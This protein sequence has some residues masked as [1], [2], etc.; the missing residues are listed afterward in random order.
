VGGSTTLTKTGA[1]TIAYQMTAA[2]GSYALSG[3]GTTFNHTTSTPASAPQAMWLSTVTSNSVE[4]GWW[5][6]IDGSVPDSYN[7]YR[8]DLGDGSPIATGIVPRAYDTTV[9]SV[10]FLFNNATGLSSSTSYTFYVRGVVGGVPGA[11]GPNLTVTTLA[12]TGTTPPTKVIDPATYIP[13][14][15]P[16][17]GG[18]TWTATQ[19]SA[20]ANSGTA[21]TGTG[22]GGS[23]GCS[24]KWA[25]DH[26][27]PG[28]KI[29]LTA[30]LTYTSNTANAAFI[31]NTANLWINSSIEPIPYSY[32]IDV[33]YVT[34]TATGAN[35]AAGAT[36][37]TL[38]APFRGRSGWYMVVFASGNPSGIESRSAL[39]VTDSANVV[40][41]VGLQ[42]NCTTKLLANTT[43]NCPTPY[44]AGI[45]I[46]PSNTVISS[47]IMPTVQFTSANGPNGGYGISINGANTRLVGIC[48]QPAPGLL[49]PSP[50]FD[51]ANTYTC[52]VI[53]G[54]ADGSVVDRC[55]AGRDL[56]ASNRSWFY[57]AIACGADNAVVSQCYLFGIDSGP[58]GTDTQAMNLTAGGP[59]CMQNCYMEAT[60]EQHISGGF[61]IPQSSMPHD[62]TIRFCWTHK[63]TV[64]QQIT[65][66]DQYGANAS[67]SRKVKNHLEQKCIYGWSWHDNLMQNDAFL[68]A[69]FG[70]QGRAMPITPRDQISSRAPRVITTLPWS[71]VNGGTVTCT[72]QYNHNVAV[73]DK[74]STTIF[75]CANTVYNG[76]FVVTT[77]A[78]NQFTY[79][80]P[81]GSAPAP[82]GGSPQ[83]LLPPQSCGM[84]QNIFD[85]DIYN[86]QAYGV[87]SLGYISTNIDYNQIL[88]TARERWH[89]NLCW[90][91]PAFTDDRSGSSG[92]NRGIWI[93]GRNPDTEF[94]NNTII[95]APP[96]FGYSLGFPRG[97]EILQGNA[98]TNI[99][100]DRWIVTNNI[101]DANPGIIIDT[102]SGTLP[103]HFGATGG[104]AVQFSFESNL[105]WDKNLFIKDTS[106]GANAF[107]ATTYNPVDY[108]LVGFKNFV[109]NT[110]MPGSPEDYNVVTGTYATAGTDGR[111]LGSFFQ[112]MRYPRLAANLI[113]LL[114]IASLGSKWN[115]IHIGVVAFYPGFSAGGK[116]AA[117][118][119]AAVRALNLRVVL[120]GYTIAEEITNVNAN[121]GNAYNPLWNTITANN[122]FARTTYPSGAVVP[123]NSGGAAGTEINTTLYSNVVS[124]QNYLQYRANFDLTYNPLDVGQLDGIY[125]DDVFWKPRVDA[126]WNQNGTVELQTDPV[127]QQRYRDGYVSLISTKRSVQPYGQLQWGNI[128]DWGANGTTTA[129]M[130]AATQGYQGM[131]DGGFMEAIIGQTFSIETYAG[132]A[133]MMAYYQFCHQMVRRPE[134]L[135]FSQ[136]GTITDYQSMRYGL[137]SCLLGDAAYVHSN[138]S[139]YNDIVLYDEFG[140]SLGR[141]RVPA[142]PA[143]YYAQGPSGVYRRDFENGIILVNP[144]GNGS[145]TVTLETTYHKF[146]GTQAPGIN[147]G[148]AVT[149]VTL[150][151][152]DGLFLSRT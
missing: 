30:G 90:C 55:V 52:I 132:W 64:W 136:D 80:L 73:G 121:P 49:G 100:N 129:T 17:T 123:S 109:S 122:W 4:V 147:N 135:I 21:G 112:I 97:F 57:R 106:S 7:A 140:F 22:T 23:V 6:P 127:V 126:D 139:N 11:A 2:R 108:N 130:I 43:C 78:A 118:Q 72:L 113:G 152:R 142:F 111:S 8:A 58:A 34:Y 48:V 117:Q 5:P 71:S 149:S 32:V 143:K 92:N 65:T 145:Q 96:S 104:V 95:I 67:I 19:N 146:T 86:N 81:L 38:N 128:A 39:F 51:R 16:P 37:C 83:Y 125:T 63:P 47:P 75:G 114:D 119:I 88:C 77:I 151:D 31:V 144:K 107:P 25:L 29:T 9:P 60:G 59:L 134:Q 105:V 28:D 99:L 12:A 116:T 76:T 124:G 87:L 102:P 53:N 24:F 68:Y 120:T 50:T 148:A 82:P 26:A 41:N 20:A 93:T 46:G 56:T 103:P 33:S 13:I 131:L 91:N 115:G 61:F 137:C 79:L 18:T 35:I 138:G 84:W 15:N 89:N 44:D 3:I 42:A 74:F 110:T 150:A 94:S 69:S 70:Q 45:P 66:V 54:S 27:A 40:W 1:G 101:M 62:E 141:A 133:P 14:Y 85:G 98:T 10:A 36:G